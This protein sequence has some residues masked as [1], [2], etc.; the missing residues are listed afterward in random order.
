MLNWD[1]IAEHLEDAV[2]TALMVILGCI[3]GALL[4][5]LLAVFV[6]GFY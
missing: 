4:G 3:G 1:E 2:F 5:F 6:V